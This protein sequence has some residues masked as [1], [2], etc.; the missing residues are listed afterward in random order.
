MLRYMAN[1][2][3][4]IKEDKTVDLIIKDD[5]SSAVPKGLKLLRQS[6]CP[7]NVGSKTTGLFRTIMEGGNENLGETNRSLQKTSVENMLL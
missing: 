4:K 5:M 7:M 1:K 2:P 3:T 6:I